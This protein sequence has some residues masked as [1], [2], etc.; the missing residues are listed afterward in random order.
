VLIF[1]M[2]GAFAFA[3]QTVVSRGF[4][5]MQNTLFPAIFGTLA[6]ALSIPLYMAG[7]RFMGVKGVALAM[8]VS[9][10]LQVAVL[11]TAWNRY[12]RNDNRRAVY[13]AFGKMILLSV[14]AGFFLTGFRR[15]IASGIDGS[16]FVGSLT[17]AMLTGA[18]FIALLTACGYLLD[19]EEVRTGLNRIVRRV[20]EHFSR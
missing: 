7:L 6:V 8:S 3:A 14:P 16:T 5:A 9:V 18:V 15:A 2:P 17:I 4:Y 19:I 20:K 13:A 11:F 10:V 12:S 1:L